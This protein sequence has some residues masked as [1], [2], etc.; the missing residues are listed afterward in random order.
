VAEHAAIVNKM[1]REI[2]SEYGCEVWLTTGDP[3]IKQTKEHTGT[4][5]LQEYQKA[6]IY[7][8]VDSIPTDRRIGLQK[9]QD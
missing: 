7:I 3:A 9:I 4:S 2:E 5:I 1:T 6:G 8:S